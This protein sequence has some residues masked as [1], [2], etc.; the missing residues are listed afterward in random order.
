VDEITPPIGN[1]TSEQAWAKLVLP[2][3]G[4]EFVKEIGEAN[5]VAAGIKNLHNAKDYDSPQ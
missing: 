4:R 5:I 2:R 1:M 3:L